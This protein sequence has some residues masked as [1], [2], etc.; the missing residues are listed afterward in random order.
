MG[1]GG[2]LGIVL[3]SVYGERF[4]RRDV[5]FAGS[6]VLT[7]LGLTAT[8]LIRTVAGGMAW[9]TV[10]GLGAGAAYVMGFTHLHENVEDELRGRTFAAL[11][12]LMRVGLLVSMAVAATVPSVIGTLPAPLDHT[13]RVMIFGGGAVVLLSG[14]GTLWNMR[15]SFRR[16]KLSA[17][18]VR[19]IAAAARDFTWFR[20]S[21]EDL[22]IEREEDG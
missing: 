9:M 8:G 12:S 10:V 11:F 14:V 1:T 2:G 4:L 16:P 7:G 22:A 21:R 5:V 15:S 3:L 6:L 19:S 20:G 17:A 13:S 18:A